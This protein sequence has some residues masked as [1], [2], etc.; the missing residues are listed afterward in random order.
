MQFGRNEQFI[1]ATLQVLDTSSH[2]AIVAASVVPNTSDIA[3]AIRP[4][5]PCGM[6]TKEQSGC[7]CIGRSSHGERSEDFDCMGSDGSRTGVC[8]ICKGRK[9]LCAESLE[10]IAGGQAIGVI[11]QDFAFPLGVSDT[12]DPLPGFEGGINGKE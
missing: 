5:L 3:R 4:A 12:A 11:S 10:V 7:T 9:A 2:F 8:L 6:C 1:P